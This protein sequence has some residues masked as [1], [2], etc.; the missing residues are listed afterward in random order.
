MPTFRLFLW[1]WLAGLAIFALVVALGL[2]LSTPE[3]PGGI[4]DHQAAGTGAEIDRIQRAWAGAG[5]L[6]RARIAMAA[7]LVF[8]GVYGVGSVLGGLHFSRAGAGLVS[9]LGKL[10]AV[11][12]AVFLVTDYAETIC[13]LIQLTRFAGAD[14]LAGIA[15][16]A[17]PPKIAAWIVTM[18]GVLV[19]LAWKWRAGRPAR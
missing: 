8:I 5:L 7:D 17:R 4:L 19:A 12:G 3:V 14:T 11:A 15:A 16:A 1:W 2:P 13:Q 9:A 10:V 18:L 6:D